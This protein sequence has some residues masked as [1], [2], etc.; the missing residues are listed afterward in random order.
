MCVCVCVTGGEEQR[1]FVYM[2]L[3]ITTQL[4][5]HGKVKGHT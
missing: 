3:C 1:E 2:H 4:H 5:I